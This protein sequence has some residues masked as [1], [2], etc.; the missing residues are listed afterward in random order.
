MRARNDDDHRCPSR[1]Q[2]LLYRSDPKVCSTIAVNRP[3][4][5]SPK[6]RKSV[7]LRNI[8]HLETFQR[9]FVI[10]I[11]VTLCN[12]VILTM[13]IYITHFINYIKFN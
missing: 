3:W 6:K 1:S 7:L 9:Y 8:I 2:R 13:Y 5:L 12:N 4:S 10:D 11:F